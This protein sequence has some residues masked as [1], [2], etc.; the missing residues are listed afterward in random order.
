MSNV[1]IRKLEA[2]AKKHKKEIGKLMEELPPDYNL[3]TDEIDWRSSRLEDI[4]FELK[5]LKK[6]YK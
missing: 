6:K 3:I 2:E 4:H 1:R 5:E